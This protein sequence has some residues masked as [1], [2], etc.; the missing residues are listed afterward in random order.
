MG[1]AWG[2]DARTTAVPRHG[3]IVLD[4]RFHRQSIRRTIAVVF[5]GRA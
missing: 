1:G 4:K 3:C 5:Q 2:C